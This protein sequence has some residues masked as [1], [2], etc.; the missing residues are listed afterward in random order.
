MSAKSLI[1]QTLSEAVAVW[2]A[3]AAPFAFGP[4]PAGAGDAFVAACGLLMEEAE[5][6]ERGDLR[7]AIMRLKEDVLRFY[8]DKLAVDPRLGFGEAD[9][10]VNQLAR[11]PSTANDKESAL[12]RGKAKLN[13]AIALKAQNPDWTNK[14]I[15]AAVG[16]SEKYLSSPDAN[17]YKRLCKDLRAAHRATLPRGS[18]GRDEEMEAWDDAD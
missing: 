9:D 6:R 18:K 13:A 7:G 10:A 4:P 8:R 14:Q 5:R 1:P 2:R 16:C 15:A 12:P 3:T 17:L 11:M